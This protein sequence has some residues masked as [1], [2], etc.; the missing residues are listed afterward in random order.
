MD[1]VKVVK[2]D[3]EVTQW[4]V[5]MYDFGGVAFGAITVELKRWTY[6]GLLVPGFASVSIDAAGAL[7]LYATPAF[8]EEMYAIVLIAHDS[9]G[10]NPYTE[11]DT[12]IP[13]EPG[14][15]WFHG[16]SEYM[17]NNLKHKNI[18]GALYTSHDPLPPKTIL[19]Q[20]KKMDYG[21]TS[22]LAYINNGSYVDPKYERYVGHW[23]RLNPPTPPKNLEKE[24]DKSGG[25]G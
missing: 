8:P 25:N 1:T 24:V 9:I 7:T 23:L 3:T 10:G 15:Y 11:W 2:T 6:R 13:T 16:T 22:N 5:P 21:V 12:A 17:R 4:A 18:G 20:V 19:V 14:Y